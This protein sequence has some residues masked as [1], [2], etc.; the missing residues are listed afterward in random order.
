MPDKEERERGEE[1]KTKLGCRE[2]R[3]EQYGGMNGK[4]NTTSQ[5]LNPLPSSSNKLLFLLLITQ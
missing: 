1:N 4:T 3:K 2:E 5:L